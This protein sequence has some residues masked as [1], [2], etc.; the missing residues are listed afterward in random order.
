M[1]VTAETVI[2]RAQISSCINMQKIIRSI[3]PVV[4]TKTGNDHKPLQASTNDD[5]PPPNDH[6]PP[7]NDHKPQANDHKPLA[8]NNKPPAN[9]NKL[10]ANDLKPRT[11]NHN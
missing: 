6:K 8:N 3:L 11:N 1:F 9:N 5:K 2:K 4:V 10:P 7:E